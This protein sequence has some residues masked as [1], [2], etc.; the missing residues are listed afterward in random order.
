L[1]N[2][3]IRILLVDD[4]PL[5]RG[6]LRLLLRDDPEAAIVGEAGDGESALRKIRD[7]E[8]DLVFLDI[9][10]AR[11]TGFEVLAAIEEPRR[12]AVIFVTAFDAHALQ[13][14]EVQALDYLLKPFDDERFAKAFARA[15]THIRQR[16]AHAIAEQL[17][18]ALGPRPRSAPPPSPSPLPANVP[19][20]APGADRI[21]I[22]SGGRVFFL[23]VG[24]IDWIAA[25]DYYVEVHAGKESHL[26]RESMRDMEA[27]LDPR[28]FV[29]IH[30]SAIVNVERIREM[31]T[32][33]SGEY[34]VILSDG[35]ELKLSRSRRD[36]ICALLGI[37]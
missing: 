24:D 20:A 32:V 26:V 17:V 7:L 11:K 21:A 13:A 12:P 36:Q 22:R 14:F 27:R 10:M 30:R 1:D 37:A 19:Q 8:P 18:A 16:R 6:A 4:E 34:E 9:Q 31:R 3:G 5:A 33:A 2:A 35:T 28:R 29:R 23:P 15:K 25:E